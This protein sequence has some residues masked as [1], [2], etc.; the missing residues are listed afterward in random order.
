MLLNLLR[1]FLQ[2]IL[3]AKSA[4]VSSNKIK[5]GHSLQSFQKKDSV[6]QVVHNKLMSDGLSVLVA[7]GGTD[8][9]CVIIVIV[10]SSLETIWL[11]WL[12]FRQWA[13][14]WL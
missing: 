6:H 1:N 3:S 2:Q 14:A 11:L 8:G 9:Q 5:S 12:R 10:E 13:I 7:T 4:T